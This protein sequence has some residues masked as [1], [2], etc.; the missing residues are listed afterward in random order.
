AEFTAE[1]GE[2]VLVPVDCADAPAVGVEKLY[3]FAAHSAAGAG[4]EDRFH[5]AS[6]PLF[7]GCRIG[8]G[9]AFAHFFDAIKRFGHISDIAAFPQKTTEEP[10]RP[11]PRRRAEPEGLRHVRAVSGR[12]H[13]VVPVVHRAVAQQHREAELAT[14]HARRHLAR[15]PIHRPDLVTPNVA[16]ELGAERRARRTVQP[17]RLEDL[18]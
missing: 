13:A 15:R 11:E 5:N 14:G 18:G 7:T 17:F 8:F 12:R 3:P 16:P 10:I 4:Y 2:A 6:A 9:T 1:S